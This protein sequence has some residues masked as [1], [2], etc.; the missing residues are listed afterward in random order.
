MDISSLPVEFV[1]E[2]DG[3]VVEVKFGIGGRI[4]K[5]LN[6]INLYFL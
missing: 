4:I 2:I 3:I 1:I 6:R 5:V